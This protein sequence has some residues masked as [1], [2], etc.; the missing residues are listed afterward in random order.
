M[1]LVKSPLIKVT[2]HNIYA[3]FALNYISNNSFFKLNVYNSILI[4]YLQHKLVIIYFGVSP[5]NAAI[6]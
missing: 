5:G 6:F 3:Y 1:G 4:D 2:S